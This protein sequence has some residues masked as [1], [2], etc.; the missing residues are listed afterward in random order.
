MCRP[1]RSDFVASVAVTVPAPRCGRSRCVVPAGSSV[2]SSLSPTKVRVASAV[3]PDEARWAAL[4]LGSTAAWGSLRGG[5]PKTA[6]RFRSGQ[7]GTREGDPIATGWG[8]ATPPEPLR[9]TMMSSVT[10][11]TAPA[12]R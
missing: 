3:A 10:A 11:M 5:R 12:D 4:G 2:A 1:L 9:P 6:T 8:S 7:R